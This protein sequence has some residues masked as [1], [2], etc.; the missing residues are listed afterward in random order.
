MYTLTWSCGLRKAVHSFKQS[1]QGKD[2]NAILSWN[3][4]PLEEKILTGT[5]TKT[6]DQS[7]EPTFTWG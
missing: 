6:K 1:S 3:L 7:K 4:S 2:S 5:L